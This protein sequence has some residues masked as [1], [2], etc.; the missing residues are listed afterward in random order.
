MIGHKTFTESTVNERMSDLNKAHVP[1]G[2]PNVRKLSKHIN[3]YVS[4]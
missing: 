2:K 1:A 3:D 4:S